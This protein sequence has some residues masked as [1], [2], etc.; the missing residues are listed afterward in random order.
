VLVVANNSP[1]PGVF[2]L[3]PGRWRVLESG[4]TLSGS[5]VVPPL[6]AWVLLRESD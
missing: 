1:R 6:Y 2:S 3:P 5:T 4:A